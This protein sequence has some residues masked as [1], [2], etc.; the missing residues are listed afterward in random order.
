MLLVQGVEQLLRFLGGLGLG[1]GLDEFLQA[2][3]G[4][5]RLAVIDQFLD[6]LQLAGSVGLGVVRLR[7]GFRVGFRVRFRVGLR[8]GVRF[9]IRLGVRFG[10]G[11]RVGLGRLL[12]G[13]ETALLAARD[14]HQA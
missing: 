14:L 13:L 10:V 2:L 1:I 5:V 4:L 8:L 12:A 3:L 6:Q 7:V 11:L 9:R